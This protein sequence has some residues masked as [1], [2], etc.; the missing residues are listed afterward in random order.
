MESIQ[1]LFENARGAT[2]KSLG[3]ITGCAAGTGKAARPENSLSRAV[4]GDAYADVSSTQASL[5]NIL[6]L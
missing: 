5:T 4:S 2:D 1:G 3:V 6:F